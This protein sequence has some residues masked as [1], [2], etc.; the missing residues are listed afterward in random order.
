MLAIA[1]TFRIGDRSYPSAEWLVYRTVAGRVV[2]AHVTNYPG[3]TTGRWLIPYGD[4]RELT[5]LSLLNVYLA[6]PVL[7][8]ATEDARI[9][10]ARESGSFFHSITHAIGN[11]IGDVVDF[12]IEINRA[13]LQPLEVDSNGLQLT[14]FATDALEDVGASDD[15]IDAAQLVTSIGGY[16]VVAGA[17]LTAI[18]GIGAITD[19]AGA[20][21]DTISGVTGALSGAQ[22]V[23]DV[24]TG[25][26][27]TGVT[28]ILPPATA[29]AAAE[30]IPDDVLFVGGTGLVIGALVVWLLLRRR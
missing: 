5:R 7:W 2:R 21:G 16:G 29:A 11:A 30:G 3:A 24:V 9:I 1:S 20:V 14:H 8:E 18:G 22:E 25:F 4:G 23:L 15:L 28:P 6:D 17:A 26:L 10:A 19:A 27:P 13:V 12:G